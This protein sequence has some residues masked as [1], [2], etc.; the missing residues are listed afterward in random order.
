MKTRRQLLT[1]LSIVLL[2]TLLS[3]TS[4][5][6]QSAQKTPVAC[7]HPVLTDLVSRIGGE[8]VEVHGLMKP[9]VDA[10]TYSPTPQDTKQLLASKVIFASGKGLE[11]YLAAVKDN[12]KADQTLVEVG[13]SVPS[14][15][16][17]PNDAL[18]ACCPH[19]AKNALDP[20]WW[21]SLENMKRAGDAVAQALTK[22]SPAGK[23]TFQANAKTW[24]NELDEL[25][26]W[27][28]KEIGTIPK[29]RRV[30]ATGHLS[31]SY[32]AKEFGFKLLPVQGL[33][34][35]TK[36]IASDIASAVLKIRELGVP[37]VFP[38]QGSN[39]RHIQEIQRET[40]T[41]LGAP[42]IMDMNAAPPSV[43]FVAA[44]QHNIRSLVSGLK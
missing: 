32:F 8:S 14:L 10:H 15:V 36:P 6:A 1:Y 5:L 29:P 33:N 39:L 40:G 18:Y 19:H 3:H 11:N 41:K 30:I 2:P 26:S 24:R 31:L 28:R 34:S 25:R 13:A 35:Q 20:H 37:T 42:L 12:L 27:A 16:V 21:N 44:F 22:V 4:G 9:G 43:G 38:E 17:D 23:D 7:L